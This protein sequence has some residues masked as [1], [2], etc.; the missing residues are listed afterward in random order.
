MIPTF[1]IVLALSG[2][3]VGLHRF[4][5]FNHSQHLLGAASDRRINQ[6]PGDQ[7]ELPELQALGAGRDRVLF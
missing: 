4:R 1:H 6:R 7:V 3:D 5:C 2:D